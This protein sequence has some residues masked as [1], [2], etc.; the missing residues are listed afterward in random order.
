M[1]SKVS[2]HITTNSG[3]EKHVVKNCFAYT[4]EEHFK[5]KMLSSD[6]HGRTNGKFPVEMIW[7]WAAEVIFLPLAQ[8]TTVFNAELLS[9]CHHL[10]VSDV[11]IK[12]LLNEMLELSY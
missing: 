8:A 12:A 4:E 5:L 6:Q 10:E 1:V 2:T 3:K 9:T 11:Q 7:F